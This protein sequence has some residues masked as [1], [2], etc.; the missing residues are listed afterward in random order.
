MMEGEV[1]VEVEVVSCASE[2]D[3]KYEFSAPQYF[4]F[5]YE[6]TQEDIEEAERWFESAI[7]YEA[8]RKFYL[9][10]YKIKQAYNSHF[11]R[12]HQ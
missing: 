8:S 2:F 4:D 6:E 3:W 11:K 10:L 9:C 5:A 7:P 1:E 12:R